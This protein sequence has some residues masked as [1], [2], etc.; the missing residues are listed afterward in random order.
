MHCIKAN[1]FVKNRPIKVLGD[2][3]MESEATPSTVYPNTSFSPMS[4]KT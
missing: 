3:N 1:Y 4:L 2:Y